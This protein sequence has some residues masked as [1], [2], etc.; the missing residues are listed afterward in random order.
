MVKDTLKGFD[1]FRTYNYSASLGTTVYGTFNFK[2]GKK[3]QSIR[4][5]IRPSISYSTQPSFDQY[6]DTYIIDA[7]GNT[8]E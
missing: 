5:T 4:H 7:D 3:L 6:Y 1:A 2:E 8:A